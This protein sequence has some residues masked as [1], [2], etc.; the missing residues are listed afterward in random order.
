[1]ND[2]LEAPQG[3]AEEVVQYEEV[4]QISEAS[5]ETESTEGKPVE[6]PAEET[7]ESEDEKERKSRGERRRE[8]REKAQREL[9]ESEAKREEA[10][11]RVQSIREASKNL[12][13]PKQDDFA[14]YED[15]QAAL[16]AHHAVK[17]LD[18]R[19]A[20]KLEAEARAQFE[21]T[22]TLRQRQA[23]EDAESW[24]SQ[25]AEAAKRYTDFDK[26]ALRDA[27]VT[28]DMA[29]FI[30]RSDVGAD[31]AYHLGKNRELGVRISQMSPMEMAMTFGRLEATV[32]AP[33]APKSSNA[34]PPINPVRGK[35]TATK[36]P[37]DMSASEYRAWVEGGGKF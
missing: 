33:Q 36:D 12:P 27:Y 37:G 10:E 16:S 11:R 35:G 34:P 3:G 24:Q 5:E 31:I 2:E 23:Q 19:E 8:A 26:V 30:S 13:T 6:A 32:S 22:K 4:G 18:S 28:E 29:K 7:Q 17:M 20:Q 1:M 21:L 25:V 15:F 14:T 9:R